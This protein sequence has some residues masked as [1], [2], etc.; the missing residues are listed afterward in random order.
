MHEQRVAH[1]DIKPANVLVSASRTLKLGDFGAALEV[2]RGASELVDS[3]VGT[4]A[5]Q[6]PEACAGA[7][8]NVF[9]ADLWALGV[10]LHAMLFGRLPWTA[11][12]DPQLFALIRAARLELPD[13]PRVS[14]AARSLVQRMLASDAAQRP[15]LAELRAHEWLRA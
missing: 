12:T 1:R 14:H 3:T 4:F 10:V 8:F 9:A 2:P 15:S 7:R 13:A 5:F 6:C 11:P